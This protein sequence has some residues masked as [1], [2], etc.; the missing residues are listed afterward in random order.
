MFLV[1]VFTMVGSTS[2][3]G[4]VNGQLELVGEISSEAPVALTVRLGRPDGSVVGEY[5]VDSE[6]AHLEL[7]AGSY[8]V[9]GEVRPI[10]IMLDAEP[11]TWTFAPARGGIATGGKPGAL[12]ATCQST[13]GVSSGGSI[14]IVVKAGPN[15]CEI[16]LRPG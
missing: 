4:P 6:D 5:R 14:R 9:T 16:R 8:L 7:P 1:A 15:A 11:G 3:C 13:V 2:A 10:E 12:H